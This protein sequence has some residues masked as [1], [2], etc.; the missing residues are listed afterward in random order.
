MKSLNLTVHIYG[1]EHVILNSPN[2]DKYIIFNDSGAIEN[3]NNHIDSSEI[4]TII[5]EWSLDVSP[6]KGGKK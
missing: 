4:A 2:S 5:N 3:G 1:P 6:E